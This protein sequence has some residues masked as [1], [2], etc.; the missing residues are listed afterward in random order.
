MHAAFCI[1]CKYYHFQQ[2]VYLLVRIYMINNDCSR[3]I[4]MLLVE[5]FVI[6]YN[7]ESE[8]Q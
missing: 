8:H 7:V 2:N 3:E 5:R 1:T 4:S 6:I